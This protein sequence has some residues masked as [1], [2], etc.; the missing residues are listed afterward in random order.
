MKLPAVASTTA[1]AL[2]T[3]AASFLLAAVLAIARF[4]S[5]GIINEKK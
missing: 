1:F 3:V 4:P 5:R 2:A